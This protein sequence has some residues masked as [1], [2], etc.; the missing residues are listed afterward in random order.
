MVTEIA[1]LNIRP[2]KAEEFLDAFA[3]AQQIIE[4]MNGYLK[5]EL[6]E[7][8]EEENKYILIVHWQNLE[9]HTVGFRESIKYQEWKKI[10]HHFYDPFPIV[11]HYKRVF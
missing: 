3:E 9:D 5:H 4:K 10:L 1:L 2:G 7:C 11:E 8:I 6:Q